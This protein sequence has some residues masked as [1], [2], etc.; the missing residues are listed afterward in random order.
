MKDHIDIIDDIK[1][2]FIEMNKGIISDKEICLVTNKYK[3]LLNAMDEVYQCIIL[4]M[5]ISLKKLE[6]IFKKKL[7]RELNMLYSILF[8]LYIFKLKIK[9]QD[10]IY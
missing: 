4:L 9:R 10:S 6:F 3:T 2:T 5:V 8:T 1:D 7:W